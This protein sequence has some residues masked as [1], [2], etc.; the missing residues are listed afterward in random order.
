[1]CVSGYYLTS[2]GLCAS[3]CSQ[4]DSNNVCL[5]CIS[6]YALN[7]FN[8]C[9]KT[10]SGCLTY[11]NATCVSCQAGLQL[12]QGIC[13]AKYCIS[14]QANDSTICNNCQPRFYPLSNGL[15]YPRNCQLFD[16]SLWICTS[17]QNQFGLINNTFCFTNNC[18]SY[19]VSTYVCTQC[20]NTSQGF[21]QL[22]IV[23]GS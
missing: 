20:Q 13:L 14:Y 11:N 21:Y 22:S 2:S 18:V 23:N 19:N 9:V 7:N 17:C 15:C 4:V 5:Q 12:V 8:Q 3:F 1:V 6:G 10:I 16:T